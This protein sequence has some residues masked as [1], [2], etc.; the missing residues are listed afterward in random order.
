VKGSFDM[1]LREKTITIN[2]GE[3][4]IVPH[5]VEHR[6]VAKEE[7]EI[8]LFEPASTLNTGNVQNELT[9]KDLESI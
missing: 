3:F 5:G 6:P 7:V 1:Q 2:A 4:L 9:V 8:L